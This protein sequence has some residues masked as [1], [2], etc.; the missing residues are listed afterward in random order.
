[1]EKFYKPEDLFEFNR[2]YCDKMVQDVM[3]KLK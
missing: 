2:I 3:E 1:M